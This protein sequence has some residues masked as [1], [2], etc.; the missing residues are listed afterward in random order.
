VVLYE[1]QLGSSRTLNVSDLLL[2]WSQATAC[3]QFE[4]AKFENRNNYNKNTSKLLLINNL[5]PLFFLTV[6]VIE[7]SV[8]FHPC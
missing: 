1:P 7:P 2:P 4:K 6:H 5:F 8:L 3:I